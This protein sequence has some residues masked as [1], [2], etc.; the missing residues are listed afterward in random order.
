MAG[1]GKHMIGLIMML[2]AV[3]VYRLNRAAAHPA[4][5]CGVRRR[6]FDFIKNV[7]IE[8]IYT[9]IALNAKLKF[10]DQRTTPE[11]EFGRCGSRGLMTP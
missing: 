1:I 6:Q 2:F 4:A 11:L 3:A 10:R 5:C 8:V 7:D 9:V